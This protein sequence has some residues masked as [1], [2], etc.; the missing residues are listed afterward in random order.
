MDLSYSLIFEK[1]REIE[2]KI[3][4]DIELGKLNI[5]NIPEILISQNILLSAVV[6][7]GGSIVQIPFFKLDNLI[8][9]A[10]CQLLNSNLLMI[11]QE[12]T[13]WVSANLKEPILNLIAESQKT[14]YICEAFVKLN[15]E[16]IKYIPKVLLDDREYLKK[17][18]CL[19]PMILSV[20]ELEACDYELCDVA[21]DSPE[22]SL[23]CLPEKWRTKELCNEAFNRNHLEIMRFPNAF[24]ERDLIKRAIRVCEKD[25]VQSILAL[26]PPEQ[27][28]ND[29]V[30][31][32][33][34]KD[35]GSFSLV[36]YEN[37]STELVFNLAPY[38][39]KYET[40]HHVPES[41]FNL[42]L[43]HRLIACNPMLLYGIPSRFR[44]KNLCYEA[45]SAN[46]LALGAVPSTLKNDDIYKAAISN[47]GLA[48]RYV[49]TPYRDNEIPLLAVQ[50]NGEAIEYV[51]ESIIDEVICRNAVMQ[52]PHAIYHV[53]KKLQSNELYLIAIKKI[54]SVL[55]FIPVDMRTVEQC[56]IAVEKD[57]LL[58]DFVPIQLRENP[59]LLR[60]AVKLGLIEPEVSVEV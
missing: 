22:F 13:S 45:I 31:N 27:F 19:N 38:M 3:I 37:I 8:C 36:P 60:L 55:K 56:L 24:I 33:F 47:N 51:P 6:A 25:E 2:Q 41:L 32:A 11:P 30:L 53:P 28:D 57:K 52:N 26:L 17:L 40:L 5:L 15:H 29:L 48:L 59:R 10:A 12:R 42:N 7:E 23:E 16:N 14:A 34:K 44:T 39:N 43:C 58:Y 49:P 35:E 46:G 18:C 20:L 21:M 54:P 4:H 9:L 50:Q 1:I